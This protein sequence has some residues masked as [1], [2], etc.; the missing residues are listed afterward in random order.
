MGKNFQEMII[1]SDEQCISENVFSG[2]EKYLEQAFHFWLSYDLGGD[3]WFA[4]ESAALFY[5]LL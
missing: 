4:K 3:C 1:L 5:D 2:M